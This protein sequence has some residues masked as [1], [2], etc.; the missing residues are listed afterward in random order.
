MAWHF[1]ISRCDFRKQK[2][3]GINSNRDLIWFRFVCRAKASDSHFTS[4]WN[5]IQITMSRNETILG[6]RWGLC[7]LCI[8]TMLH[9]STVINIGCEKTIPITA[10]QRNKNEC[11][12]WFEKERQE[13]RFTRSN[14]NVSTAPASLQML[15][16]GN[17]NQ[18][19]YTETRTRCKGQLLKRNQFLISFYRC[20]VVVT[21]EL[22]I[23]LRQIRKRRFKFDRNHLHLYPGRL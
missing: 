1:S 4:R 14:D 11:K 8:V 16:S 23:V 7:Q 20:I 15:L 2:S 12:N 6:I 10:R 3:F 19:E 21:A 13:L 17:W 22:I 18:F 9:S 5:S